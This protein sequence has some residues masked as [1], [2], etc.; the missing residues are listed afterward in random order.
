MQSGLVSSRKESIFPFTTVPVCR[1]FYPSLLATGKQMATSGGEWRSYIGFIP[2]VSS[3]ILFFTIITIDIVN[4]AIKADIGGVSFPYISEAGALNPT[5]GI[6]IA[7]AVVGCI[8]AIPSYFFLYQSQYARPL[9][10]N[11]ERTAKAALFFSV[12]GTPFIILV[13]AFSTKT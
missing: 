1:L 12:V 4:R 2:V 13:A 8:F 6:F 7:G 10:Y 5:Q 11:L 9:S 3:F